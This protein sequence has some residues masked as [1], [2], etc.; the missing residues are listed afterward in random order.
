M[1]IDRIKPD[2]DGV[3]RCPYENIEIYRTGVGGLD[4][5]PKEF[6]HMVK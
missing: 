3:I 4:A 6:P 2:K 1:L 5:E